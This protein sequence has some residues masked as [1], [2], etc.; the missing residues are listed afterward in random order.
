MMKGLQMGDMGDLFRDLKEHKRG[1]REKYAE[2]AEAALAELAAAGVSHVVISDGHLRVEQGY[3]WWPRTGRWIRLG[4]NR[5]GKGVRSLVADVMRMRSRL[6]LLAETGLET[7]PA[8]NGK[9]V[10]GG[11]FRWW[12]A[13][14]H[15]VELE[16]GKTGNGI[17]GVIKRLRSQG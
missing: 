9:L 8:R 16:T 3:D 4:Q 13:S 2:G 15:W 10:V 5:G 1:E 14:D 12:P 17:N 6:E 11:K 7:E